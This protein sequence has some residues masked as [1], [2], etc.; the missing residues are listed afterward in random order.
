MKNNK[1][2]WCHEEWNGEKARMMVTLFEYFTPGVI[3]TLFVPGF[4][5]QNLESFLTL[6]WPCLEHNKCW[7]GSANWE[8][9]KKRFEFLSQFLPSLPFLIRSC[10]HGSTSKQ[11]TNPT[12]IKSWVFKTKS[13]FPIVPLGLRSLRSP[14]NFERVWSEGSI[15]FK[16]SS[17]VETFYCNTSLYLL[18]RNSPARNYSH[19]P[20]FLSIPL[21]H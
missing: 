20:F 18:K 1:R 19:S 16:W 8:R 6:I 21:C 11:L 10:R 15:Y 13:Y 12:F 7:L 5:L 3:V 14:T 2:C 9:R 4:I 17:G